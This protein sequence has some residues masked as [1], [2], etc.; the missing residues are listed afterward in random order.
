VN[1]IFLG[2]PGVGKGTAAQKLALTESIPHISTGDIFREAV[3]GETALGEEV[4]TIVRRGDLVPD[5]ITVRLVRERLARDDARGGFI[6][7]GFPRT[8][9]QARALD[10]FAR[11]D[12]VV[13]F[14]LAESEIIRRLSG[15]RICGSCGRIYHIEDIPPR[16]PDVCDAC[17]GALVQ[18]EDDRLESIAK[19]LA[20]FREL[21]EPLIS[22]YEKGGL[23]MR[24][25]SS[26]SPHETFAQV[27]A[28]LHDER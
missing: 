20:L 12:A 24:V 11:I 19:R 1:Y 15:R 10:G 3:R 18:R 5:E 2:P 17:G 13:F 22:H 7:D 26:G 25:D 21:T 8:L 9:A 14:D 6:L 28:H 16:R 4:R 23:L 27:T